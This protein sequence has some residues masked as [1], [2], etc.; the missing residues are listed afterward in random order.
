M[1]DYG[2]HFSKKLYHFAVSQMRNHK[3]EKMQP[4][5]LERVE[6]FL[7]DNGIT[8]NNNVGYD[9]AYTISMALADYFGSSIADDRHLALFAQDY[10]D[11]PDGSET[12]AF[13]EF[14]I[15]MI[16]LGSPVFWSEMV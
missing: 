12:R 16:A 1:E 15:K 4:W 5:D 7:K 8:L 9:A 10:L 14:Y 3:G 11:D 2:R 6:K 13:D